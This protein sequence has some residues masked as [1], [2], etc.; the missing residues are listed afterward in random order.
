MSDIPADDAPQLP[1]EE[2]PRQLLA[3]TLSPVVDPD[4]EADRPSSPA[5]GDEETES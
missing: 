4:L 5:E 2:D 1:D 3:D